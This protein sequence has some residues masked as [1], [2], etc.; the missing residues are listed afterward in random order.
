MREATARLEGDNGDSSNAG[1]PR[2]SANRN[3]LCCSQAAVIEARQRSDVRGSGGRNIGTAA[4][5][6]L[7]RLA[8]YLR[9]VGLR[10]HALVSG[11]RSHLPR[12]WSVFSVLVAHPFHDFL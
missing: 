6:I 8:G 9:R 10:I 2:G 11:G 4:L 1:L 7:L 5:P 3:T 12:R